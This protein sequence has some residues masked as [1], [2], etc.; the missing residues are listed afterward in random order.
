[1]ITTWG[2]LKTKLRNL[3]WVDGEGENLVAAHD[4]SFEEAMVD[5]QM[6]VECLQQDNVTMFPACS[7]YF[8]CGL[9]V[10]QAPVGAI[11]SVS[12]LDRFDPTTKVESADAE[13]Q[14]CEEVGYNPV[15][16]CH[17]QNYIKRCQS[18]RYCLPFSYYFGLS[19]TNCPKGAYP[20]PTGEG[21]PAGLPIL[22][23]GFQYAQTSTD[24]AARALE[25]RWAMSRGKIYIGPWIQST[26]AVKV[27][28]DG[29]KT[30]WTDADPVET[31]PLIERALKAWVRRDHA[32]DWD[33]KSDEAAAADV[34]YVSA[35]QD[36]MH[37]CREETRQRDCIEVSH[38]RSSPA[39]LSALYFNDEQR[40]TAECGAG[41]TGDDV[42][43]VIQ[44]GTVGSSVSKQD[45]NQ[46]ALET[47]KS[48]AEARLV[49]VAETATYWN[50]EQTAVAEC[51]TDAQHPPVEG[52]PVTRTIPANTISS[53][54][55]KAAANAAALAQALE[56]AQSARECVWWNMAQDYTAECPSGTTGPDVI[57]SVAAHTYSS[58]IS[59]ED[60]DAQAL[61]AAKVAAESELICN[62]VPVVYQSYP[63]NG[64]VKIQC[65]R[66]TPSGGGQVVIP[67]FVT[68]TF[69][70]AAG[71]A[72]SIISQ[73]DANTLAINIG[74]SRAN[75]M[76]QNYCLGGLCGSYTLNIP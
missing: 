21:L 32:R 55:S 3:L 5:L 6:W 43:Q 18:V 11:R 8:Q 60:A 36:L 20:T 13:I 17:I 23:L 19:I 51:T 9:T 61:N 4:Q 40:Y 12:V 57:K 73:A 26:E 69:M 50:D 72:T 66:C 41:Y 29:I 27:V 76:A 75:A 53:T 46:R 47:A 70:V 16:F 24:A 34:D 62:A 35:R 38:A 10:I 2:Q 30:E 65:P 15:D 54:V 45:A 68:V 7:T 39:S 67:Q 71:Y 52:S 59:Q 25:G 58:S 28:W 42:T 14:W 31:D 74:R 22:P 63:Q 33:K 56:L 49:C 1:M 64:F 37:R 44:A 48:Q